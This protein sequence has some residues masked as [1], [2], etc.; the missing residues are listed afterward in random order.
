MPQLTDDEK[1]RLFMTLDA[2]TKQLNKLEQGMYGDK[3]LGVNG[4][5]DDMKYVKQ[6]ISKQKLRIAFFTGVCTVIGFL[7]K[8]AWEYFVNKK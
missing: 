5:I 7:L 1:A 4:L 2:Q 6:W 3:D 8:S